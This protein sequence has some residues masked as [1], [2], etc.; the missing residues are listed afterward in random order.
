VFGYLWEQKIRNQ[1]VTMQQK[2]SRTFKMPHSG[3][4]NGIDSK[5][6]QSLKIKQE[7]ICLLHSLVFGR[8]GR[9]G[10]KVEF[11]E[12]FKYFIKYVFAYCKYLRSSA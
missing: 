6:L 3:L 12:P 9:I 1:N 10:L 8:D 11:I 2:S 5:M 4:H 7:E